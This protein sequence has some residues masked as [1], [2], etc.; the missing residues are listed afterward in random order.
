MPG[1]S[2]STRRNITVTKNKAAFKAAGR[3]T[4][5]DALRRK[6]RA[7]AATTVG[8]AN[9]GHP[10]PHGGPPPQGEQL[11]S[12]MV[13]TYRGKL[14]DPVLSQWCHS[15][16]D[17]QRSFDSVALFAEARENGSRRW[18]AARKNGPP[19]LTSGDGTTRLSTS[20]ASSSRCD[21]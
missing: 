2:S 8:G 14:R 6:L 4:T 3:V 18:H 12:L 9:D 10:P 11:A 16:D 15:Y 7:A 19:P 5:P 13:A 20:R 21:A 17:E 1:R